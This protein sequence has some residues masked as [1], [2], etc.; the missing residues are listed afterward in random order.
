MIT[1]LRPQPLH[2][3]TSALDRAVQV[4]PTLAPACAALRQPLKLLSALA[5]EAEAALAD[6]HRAMERLR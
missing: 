1:V 5:T 3:L 6:D 4:D 2:R